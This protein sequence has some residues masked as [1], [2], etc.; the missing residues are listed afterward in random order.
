MV[1]G[2][3]L[4]IH[5][6]VLE[7]VIIAHNSEAAATTVDINALWLTNDGIALV[8]CVNSLQ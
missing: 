7:M 6:N 5:D 3:Q 2:R 8:S 1:M 4:L